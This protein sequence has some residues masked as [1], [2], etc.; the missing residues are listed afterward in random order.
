[1]VHLILFYTQ[2][3]ISY[4]KTRAYSEFWFKELSPGL[5]TTF[6]TN[7]TIIQLNRTV[8]SCILLQLPID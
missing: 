2:F 4:K 7:R 5:V 3:R 6:N 8:I 1:M